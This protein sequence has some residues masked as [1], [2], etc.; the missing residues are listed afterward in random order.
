MK[1]DNLPQ[2][3]FPDDFLDTLY[4][5]YEIDSSNQGALHESLENS[6][7]EWF[8]NRNVEDVDA[9]PREVREALNKIA[10]HADDLAEL[11]SNTPSAVWSALVETSGLVRRN[12]YD[13]GVHYDSHHYPEVGLIGKPAITVVGDN[14]HDPF[15]NINVSDLIDAMGELASS[16]GIASQ[17]IPKVTQGPQP[18]KPLRKWIIDMRKLMPLKRRYS[19]VVLLFRTGLRLS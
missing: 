4:Q 3:F 15:V 14:E 6:A 2:R 5:R 8:F 18:D 1:W 19:E 7:R 11:L 9:P 12:R 13:P 10:K 16:A 17:I